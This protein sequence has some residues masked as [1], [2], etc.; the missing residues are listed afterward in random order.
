MDDVR[1]PAIDEKELQKALRSEFE[2][3]I[4]EVTKA[5]NDARRGGD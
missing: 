4:E 2:S 5:V 3:C 1:L